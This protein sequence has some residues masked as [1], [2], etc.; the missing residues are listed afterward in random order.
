MQQEMNLY[1]VLKNSSKE[2]TLIISGMISYEVAFMYYS[3]LDR[4]SHES[5]A[6]YPEDRILEK[7]GYDITD[8]A[9]PILRD[10][11]LS[12]VDIIDE[13]GVKEVTKLVKNTNSHIYVELACFDYEIGLNKLRSELNRIHNNRNVENI[14]IELYEDVFGKRQVCN[15]YDS[16]IFIANHIRNKNRQ[17]VTQTKTSNVDNK[18]LALA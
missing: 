18:V 7:L 12:I 15:V 8:R 5:V 10:L 6:I 11:V 2:E 1:E 13:K 3:Y 16:I 9:T 14:D 4:K 17:S